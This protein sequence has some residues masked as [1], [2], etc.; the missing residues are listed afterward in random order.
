MSSMSIRAHGGSKCAK[1]GINQLNQP[2]NYKMY[3]KAATRTY[4][5]MQKKQ[6]GQR[7]NN[8]DNKKALRFDTWLPW[9]HTIEKVFHNCYSAYTTNRERHEWGGKSRTIKNTH[10]HMYKTHTDTKPRCDKVRVCKQWRFFSVF[11]SLC[12]FKRQE[13]SVLGGTA[14]ADGLT[15]TLCTCVSVC[16]VRLCV[17]SSKCAPHIGVVFIS[18][19]LTKWQMKHTT[20]TTTTNWKTHDFL[21]LALE[22]TLWCWIPFVTEFLPTFT[23]LHKWLP[24]LVL[25]LKRMQKCLNW[26]LLS[27]PHHSIGQCSNVTAW[28]KTVIFVNVFSFF[29]FLMA[30]SRFRLI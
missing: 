10:T 21:R 8:N 5:S 12:Q 25:L 22:L 20:Q 18:S 3:I 28:H 2:T 19:M 7:D 6:K 1:Q 4:Y 15:R 16:A 9:K 26:K 14:Y 13:L 23:L 11:P 27:I 17:I 29:L 24:V 30:D